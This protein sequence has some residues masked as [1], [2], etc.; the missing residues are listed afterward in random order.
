MS[1]TTHAPP[2]GT[3][4]TAGAVGTR[5][6]RAGPGAGS[7]PPRLRTPRA[8]HA[9]TVLLL[10]VGLHLVAE[11]ALTPFLPQLFRTLFG[12]HD[13]TATGTFLW[14]CRVA[15]CL[16]FP[17]WG[18]AARRWPAER[19]VLTG[20]CA[21]TVIYAA[22]VLAPD[23][24][25]FTALSAAVVATNAALLLAYPALISSYERGHHDDGAGGAE[26]PGRQ[27]LRGIR[28][29]VAVFHGAVVVSTVVGAA[30]MALP[31]PRWGLLVFVLL[32]ATLAVLCRRALRGVGHVRSPGRAA[33]PA[34][35]EAPPA[36]V[37][38]DAP[39]AP[40]QTRPAV[41]IRPR[42]VVAVAALAVV[43]E[44]A[45]NVVRPFFT[46]Y[47]ATGGLGTT[48]GAAQFL[49]ASLAALAVLPLAESAHRLLGRWLL[50]AGFLLAA[51]GLLWQCL[52]PDL[53]TLTAGRIVFGVGLGLGH[54]ALDLRMFGATGTAAPAYAAVQT[55]RIGGLFVSPVL[56]TLAATADLVLPLV[57]GAVLYVLGA[58][59]A[60][61]LT[62]HHPHRK[63]ASRPWP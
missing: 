59:L 37:A 58:V 3:D 24:A 61:C 23:Y 26:S 10:V 49:L 7:G 9:R 19:L 47:A 40:T 25:T 57:L 1:A 32:G 41:R 2:G 28:A 60:P 62:P 54:V 11:T 52:G 22:M 4:R 5:P 27:R 16:A 34:E 12:V 31:S 50:P 20:L 14:V 39:T 48:A 35:P 15:G 17:L 29:Y 43:F 45:T 33:T 6:G 55:A 8:P 56:A 36:P 44:I 53:L 42:H 30:V 13:L 51:A 21:S 46:E 18:L 63:E 38:P